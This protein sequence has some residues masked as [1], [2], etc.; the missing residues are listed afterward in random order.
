MHRAGEVVGAVQGL[1]ILRAPAGLDPG[2]V[3]REARGE[4]V[5]PADLPGIGADLVDESMSAVGRVVDVFGPLERPYLAVS[6]DDRDPATLLG[7]RLYAR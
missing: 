4:A 1:A 6:P 7:E 3:D 5:L 2:P